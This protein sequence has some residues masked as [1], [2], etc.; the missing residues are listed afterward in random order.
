MHHSLI[1]LQGQRLDLRPLRVADADGP[2]V[3][4]FNDPEVCLG[5]SHHVFPYTREAALDFIRYA[6]RARTEL[7][8]AMI[9]RE[10]GRHIGNIALQ[11][12]HPIYHSAELSLVIGD[13][14]CWGQ[15]YGKE[16]ARLICQHGFAELN[17][18]RI[19]CGTFASN[20]GMRQL[21][22]SL[23]MKVEGRR[24]QAAFKQGRY[25]DVIEYGLLRREFARPRAK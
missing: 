9:V 2:Y 19:S 22:L 25:L 17:L 12:I 1:F 13:K 21:A 18:A 5:N 23:G 24:R 6:R 8:L 15:G 7:V 11:S 14:D 4:W 10:S 20:R 3:S 16:A